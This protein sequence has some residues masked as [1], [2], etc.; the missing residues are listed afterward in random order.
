MVLMQRVSG[1]KC[2]SFN[3]ITI[4]STSP[5][6]IWSPVR[7]SEERLLDPLSAWSSEERFSEPLSSR[8]PDSESESMQAHKPR[9]VGLKPTI[10]HVMIVVLWSALVLVALRVL[11]L[12]GLFAAPPEEICLS[13]A[14]V[15]TL[16]PMLL[17]TVLLKAIDRRGPVRDWYFACC[18]VAWSGLAG[19]LLLLVEPVCYILA[20]RTTRAFP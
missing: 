17:L 18:K 6:V 3:E 11:R 2:E 10:R 9:P 13:V 15:F 12:G 4:R 20:G 7:A 19:I 5:S 14:V 16:W 8:P 1:R